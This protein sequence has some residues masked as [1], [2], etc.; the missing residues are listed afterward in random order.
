MGAALDAGTVSGRIEIEDGFSAVLDSIVSK[1]GV[2]TGSMKDFGETV[3]GFVEDPIH[4]A[5][6]V[7]KTTLEGMGDFGVG[8]TAVGLAAGA[9]GK[10]LYDITNAAA[11]SGE[12]ILNFA[13][14]TGDSVAD[15]SDLSRAAQI[16][17]S[18][19]DS[20]QTMMFQMQ[21]RM[22]A[23]GPSAEKFNSSLEN[24][25]INAEAFRAADPTDR[26]GMLSEAMHAAAGNTAMMSDAI[27]IMGRGAVQNM[28][29]LLKNFDELKARGEAL[30]YQWT[31]VET[32]AAEE[33]KFSTRELSTEL[34]TIGTTIGVALMPAVELLIQGTARTILAF[35]HIADLGGLVSGT[36][37]LI[38]GAVGETALSE[39]TYGAIQDTTT[40]LWKE[41]AAEGL[42]LNEATY[43]VADSMLRL[44][45]NQ[46]TVA[47]MTG[48]DAEAVGQ[49]AGQ[50]K[51][52]NK[53]EQAYEDV[54]ARV[55]KALVD[56]QI[57]IGDVSESFRGWVADM[58]KAK[59]ST[60]DMAEITGLSVLQVDL[61][62]ASIKK[63]QT[64]TDALAKKQAAATQKE[65]NDYA[66]AWEDLNS[67]GVSWKDTLKELSPATVELG[68]Y[69]LKAGAS[70]K[71]VETALKLTSE[72]AKA[73]DTAFKDNIK[74][75]QEETKAVDEL[76]ADWKK[77]YDNQALLGASDTDKVKIK[78]EQDYEVRVKKLQDLGVTD[79]K[80]YDQLWMLRELDTKQGL[81]QLDLQD[82]NSKTHLNNQLSL[83][84]QKYADMRANARD[85]TDAQLEDQAEIVADL[86]KQV[87]AWGNVSGA[88]DDVVGHVSKLKAAV[89]SLDGVITVTGTP[90]GTSAIP[91]VQVTKD[92]KAGLIA[93]LQAIE[94]DYAQFPGRAPGVNGPTGIWETGTEGLRA[95]TEMLNEQ[96]RYQ[97]L[98]NALPGFKEGG[99]G[100]FGD[101][102]LAMLHGPEFIVPFDK[103]AGGIGS[104]DVYNFNM[105]GLL[106][107]TSP[108]AKAIL[109][110]FVIEALT[111]V[112][113]TQR[114]M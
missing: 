9:A 10:E 44:G 98:K 74:T 46:K 2:S 81:E 18:S 54:S 55:N 34:A 91:V 83:A 107:D 78:A 110:R 75:V 51:M 89:E 30:A 20:L 47:M 40:R 72:Q 92:N 52:L 4:A 43:Q 12:Q 93:E 22:D 66:K 3:K 103:A 21:R 32:A 68:E 109:Q 80:A 17:G 58:E 19:L 113:R 87:D 7:V 28:P 1:L 31:D 104:G 69:Y 96:V 71:T 25:H 65:M 95:W 90:G 86:Q 59:V 41:A 111:S 37:H 36:W 88:I 56:E 6:E 33:F 70:I 23:G 13:R 67:M 39:Q 99:Y 84:Q 11:E 82:Q 64:E 85:Y 94:A 73:L 29:F 5:G 16:G 14:A 106:V 114:R 42:D 38:T 100:D 15:V 27:A 26:V 49:L 108:A 62:V 45:Y 97:A 77:Y 50:L 102:T 53:E 8:L 79:V 105:A 60:K 48:L 61:L 76:D 101:G 112:S 63:A 57:G 24:L 35:E